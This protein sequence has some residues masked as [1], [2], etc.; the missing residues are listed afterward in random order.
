VVVDQDFN[1][2][3]VILKILIINNNN[4]KMIIIVLNK[5]NEVVMQ[6]EVVIAVI[7]EVVIVVLI[8]IINNNSQ[9]KIQI[10]ILRHRQIQI[11]VIGVLLTL[12]DNN[13][14]NGMWVIGMVKHLFI[15]EQLKMMNN[16]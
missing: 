13:K 11:G 2:T 16:Q 7:I 3:E 12:L 8:E 5:D 9:Y 4:S 15:Q 14:I 6:I 1:K 10:L